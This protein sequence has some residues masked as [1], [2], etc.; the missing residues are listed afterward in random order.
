MDEERYASHLPVLKA[1]CADLKPRRVLE[2]G[3]G[4]HS[5]AFFLGLEGLEKLVSVEVDAR[6]ELRMRKEFP[7][8]RLKLVGHPPEKME[9]FQL[10][11]IDDGKNAAEREETIR[12]VLGRPHPPVVIHDAEVLDYAL[13][14]S[15]CSPLP[16]TAVVL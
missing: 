15:R 9:D 8:E 14:I 10:V 12:W 11:F 13:A 7:D 2:F 1:L 3:A 16:A 5:T 4:F 6:W